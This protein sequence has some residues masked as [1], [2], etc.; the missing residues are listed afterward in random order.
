V[1]LFLAEAAIL[2]LVALV[3]MATVFRV[4]AARDTLL[5]GRRLLFGYAIGI[6]I[7]AAIELWREGF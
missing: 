1:K 5:F 4:Q 2:L 3:L 6:L 7:L